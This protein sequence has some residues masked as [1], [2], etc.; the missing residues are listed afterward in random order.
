MGAASDTLS[1]SVSESASLDESSAASSLRTIWIGVATAI[2]VALAVSWNIYR[3]ATAYSDAFDQMTHAYEVILALDAARADRT[4]L[5]TEFTK[6]ELG[7]DRAGLASFQPVGARVKG[8]VERIGA[9]T[10]ANPG[11]QRRL[12][13][14]EKQIEDLNRLDA[15]IVKLG[16][17]AEPHQASRPLQFIAAAQLLDALRIELAG[18]SAEEFRVLTASTSQ[19]RARASESQAIAAVGCALI[20]V[21]LL[22]V[23][24]WG[25]RMV[26]R[27]DHKARQVLAGEHAL[28]QVNEAL[29]ARVKSRTAALAEQHNLLESILDAMSEAVVAVNAQGEL[30]IRNS[31][32]ELLLGRNLADEDSLLAGFELIEGERAMPMTASLSPLRTVLDGG[33]PPQLSLRKRD[34]QNNA[35]RWFECSARPVAGEWG[36]LGGAVMV[37]RDVTDRE[38]AREQLQRTHDGA[39]AELQSRSE[40]VMRTGFQVRTPLSAIIGRADLLLLSDLRGESRRHVEVIKS[41]ADLLAT[42]VNDVYDYSLLS[43]GRLTLRRVD[44]DLLDTVEEVVES[45][46]RETLTRGVELGLFVDSGLPGKLRGDPN[47]LR[48]ILYNIISNAVHATKTGQIEVNLNRAEESSSAVVVNFQV[49]DT[50]SGIAS[51]LRAHL[52]D[53]YVHGDDSAGSE[54][55]LGLAIASQLVHQMNG[56]IVLESEV[57]KGSN[58]RFRVSLDKAS[59]ERLSARFDFSTSKIAQAKVLLVGIATLMRESASRYLAA[60]GLTPSRA[61]TGAAALEMLKSASTAGEKYWGVLVAEQVGGQSGSQIAEAIK[62]ER[63][64]RPIRLLVA[65]SEPGRERSAAVDQWIRMPLMPTQLADALN[66]LVSPSLAARTRDHQS[67]IAPRRARDIRATVRILVVED[68]GVTRAMLGEQLASL[69]FAFDLAE[70]A[71]EALELLDQRSYDAVLMDLEMP[72]MDGFEATAEIR[73]REGSERHTVVIAH[74]AHSAGAI[75]RR[76]SSAGMDDFLAKP[77]TMSELAHVLDTWVQPTYVDTSASPA[78]DIDG[79]EMMTSEFDQ[80]RLSEIEELSKASGQNILAKLART[81]LADLPARLAALESAIEQGDLKT[82]ASEAHALRGA[83]GTIGARQF[84]NLCASAEDLAR[85]G[86]ATGTRTSISNLV[87]YARSLPEV[88]KRASSV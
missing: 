49:S 41:S 4:L 54:T 80:S 61:E 76:C 60:W 84:A 3:S 47:R 12:A 9:L 51:E 34:A 53:P 40:F 68:D 71:E 2:V 87:R 83:S 8:D 74:T 63:E 26:S 70:R 64:F 23:V 79:A 59:D 73:R 77:V 67:A 30:G 1:A 45:F 65:S 24:G 62:A 46:G 7:G 56:E 55:G 52:F 22:V 39:L 31:A 28:R 88:L 25:A 32:S 20:I 69:G 5:S 10:L 18:I 37:L 21:W 6:Y 15:E 13:Q 36:S 29:E 35:I 50:G 75:V 86:N 85:S 58:F 42:I 11:Q 38:F 81:F 78:K 72:G 19:A 43:T 57:G 16:A 14:I 44:F 82:F 48:Q 33:H 66:S 17:N 27:L